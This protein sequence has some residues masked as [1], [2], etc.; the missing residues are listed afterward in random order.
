MCKQQIKLAETAKRS[1]CARRLLSSCHE[2]KIL[3]NSSCVCVAVYEIHEILT[4]L[5]SALPEE[6]IQKHV[7]STQYQFRMF[8]NVD[9]FMSLHR[10][11][12]DK[13]GRLLFHN[14]VVRCNV[15]RE[16]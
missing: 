3:Q 11:H 13:A 10:R 12:L 5:E 4:A 14:T 6:E 1:D 2:A 9:C 7:R 16:M 15:R 8:K